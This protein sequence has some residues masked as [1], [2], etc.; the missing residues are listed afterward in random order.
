MQKTVKRMRVALGAKS[1]N[2]QPRSRVV[3]CVLLSPKKLVG[4]AL[5]PARE[6]ELVIRMAGIDGGMHAA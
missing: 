1:K 2:H 4:Q 6:L 3:A 5:F